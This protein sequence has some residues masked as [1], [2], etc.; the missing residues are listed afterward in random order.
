MQEEARLEGSIRAI[1]LVQENCLIC[2]KLLLLFK[3]TLM[4]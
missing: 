4:F 2:L 3:D 1:Q